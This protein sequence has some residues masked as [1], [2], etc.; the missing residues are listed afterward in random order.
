MQYKVL[1]TASGIGS[2]LGEL[3]GFTNK[4]LVTIGNKPALARIVEQYPEDIEFVVTLG[5]FGDHVKQFLEIAYPS[6]K[7]TF[8]N[9]KNYDGEGSSLGWSQLCAKQYLQCPFIYNACDTIV[10]SRPPSPAGS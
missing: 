3:T 7:F 2:R 8:V 9:V 5:Y 4:S 10:T 1:L 6:R